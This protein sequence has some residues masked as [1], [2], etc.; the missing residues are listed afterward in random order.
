ML[1]SLRAFLIGL[2][3]LTAPPLGAAEVKLAPRAVVE[4]FTSQGCSSCPKADAQLSELAARP[5]VVAL[6]WHVDYWDYMGWADSF[7]APENTARQRA[8]AEAWG[9]SRIFTPQMVVNGS[10][11]LVGGRPGTI[12]DALKSARLPVSVN[13][14][15]HD[16]RLDIAIPPQ[17]AAP[18]TVWLVTFRDRAE[19]A[20]EKGANRGQTFTYRQI[21]TGRQL[22]G[23]WNPET[24]AELSLPLADILTATSNGAAILLQS[25]RNGLPGPI[26]GAAAFTR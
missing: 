11:G 1:T 13:L 10:T 12:D 23:M 21:V 8:Y 17:G 24:G 25:D 16:D 2:L 3:T 26:L 14:T 7:G 20:I 19:I 9:S 22:L 4:L 6:A 18:A 5:D 15:A